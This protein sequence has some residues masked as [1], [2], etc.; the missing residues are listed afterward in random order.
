M[1]TAQKTLGVFDTT[2]GKKIALAVS[3][4]IIF[5][6]TIVHMLG[7][8]QVYLGPEVFNHYADTLKTMPALVWAERIVVGSSVIVHVAMMISLYDRSLK[9]RPVGYQVKRSVATTYASAAMKYTGPL[10]LLYIVYHIAHFTFPGI[11]M[12]DY[13]HS[14][15]DVYSNFVNGFSV[16]WVAVIYIFAN[17]MLG[18]H[19]YHGA[20]SMLQTLGLNHPQYN[21]LRGRLATAVAMAVTLGNISFPVSVLF[22]IIQ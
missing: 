15:T 11:S 7:N 5:G 14:P 16:P 10:L 22:G 2:V 6:F 9:A 8:L 3:G 4:A 19:L 1:Q 18:M 17:A 12:G 20:T 13:E 21:A